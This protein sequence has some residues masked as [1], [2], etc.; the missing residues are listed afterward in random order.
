LNKG[1]PEWDPQLPADEINFVVANDEVTVP[2]ARSIS[3]FPGQRLRLWQLPP[4]HF[5]IRISPKPQD[6]TGA[7]P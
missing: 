1:L 2:L 6:D 4:S 5:E 7:A 3:L